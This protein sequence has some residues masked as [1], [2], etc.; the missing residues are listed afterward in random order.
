MD[1]YLLLIRQIQAN[2]AAIE[3]NLQCLYSR[4]VEFS[5]KW[6]A[7]SYG[8]AQIGQIQD[9]TQRLLKQ[10]EDIKWSILRA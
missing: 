10:Y 2:A 1:Q 3:Q 7:L 8:T 4:E 5:Q 9:L 6:V